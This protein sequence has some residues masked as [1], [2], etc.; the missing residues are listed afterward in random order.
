MRAGYRA[1]LFDLDGTLTDSAPGITGSV[2]YA[3]ERMGRPVPPAD[4]LRRFI[5]PPLY[6]S[7]RGFC[8]MTDAEAQ[9]AVRLYR[10]DYAAGGAFRASVYP[11]VPELLGRLR[12]AGVFLAVAT[13]KPRNM[14]DRVLEHFGLAERFDFV[15]APDASVKTLTKDAVILPAVR[16]AGCAPAEAVMVGDTRY[17]AEGARLAGTA[18]IGV[19]Y[20][21]DTRAEIAAAGGSVFARTVRELSALLIDKS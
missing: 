9:E 15:S 10:E 4:A 13:S 12:A 18:F 1:A 17:D 11:G 2:R 5:G 20:G 14:T 3:L 16:A 8:G 21:T 7:F 19:L 6:P